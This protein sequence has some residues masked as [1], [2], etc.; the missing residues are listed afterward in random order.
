MLLKSNPYK[1]S[2]KSSVS[3]ALR[4][5]RYFSG[6]IISVPIAISYMTRYWL[7]R[8]TIDVDDKGSPHLD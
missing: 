7:K 1:K 2:R 5:V 3:F 6:L 4:R 8:E